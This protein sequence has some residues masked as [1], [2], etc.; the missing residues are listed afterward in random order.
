MNVHMNI[1]ISNA[2]MKKS[3]IDTNTYKFDQTN[4]TCITQHNKHIKCMNL[5]HI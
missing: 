4:N 2:M 1:L 5:K 3:W